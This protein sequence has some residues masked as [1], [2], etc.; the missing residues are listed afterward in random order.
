MALILI[1]LRI[2]MIPVFW[3]I[4][5][6]LWIVFLPA[7]MYRRYR[8]RKKVERKTMEKVEERLRQ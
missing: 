4:S 2:L 7:R 1:L 8:F 5:I 6:V 3:V